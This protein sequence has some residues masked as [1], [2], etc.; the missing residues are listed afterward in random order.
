[1]LL[2]TNAIEAITPAGVRTTEGVESIPVDVL[3]LATGFKVFE[4]GNMPAFEMLGTDGISTGG[5]VGCQPT[6]GLRGRERAG[7]S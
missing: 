6:A 2:E 7:L 4:S 5:V 1:M 3:I